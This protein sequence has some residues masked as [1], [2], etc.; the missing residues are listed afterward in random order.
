MT[1][2]DKQI[3]HQQLVN[4]FSLRVVRSHYHLHVIYPRMTCRYE[5][6]TTEGKQFW[7]LQRKITV[8]AD[9]LVEVMLW[10]EFNSLVVRVAPSVCHEHTHTHWWVPCVRPCTVMRQWKTSRLTLNSFTYNL[11]NILKQTQDYL[12]CSFVSFILASVLSPG[13]SYKCF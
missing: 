4:L 13:S 6:E 9:I 8:V 1:P 3:R 7:Y 12:P 2:S 5:L 11:V 10:L